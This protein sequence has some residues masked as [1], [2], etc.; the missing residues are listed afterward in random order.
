[1]IVYRLS[2]GIKEYLVTPWALS[3]F[4]SR[5]Y[6]KARGIDSQITKYRLV[7]KEWIKEKVK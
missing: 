3:A 1:M 6:L 4:K 5:S 2:S 7:D